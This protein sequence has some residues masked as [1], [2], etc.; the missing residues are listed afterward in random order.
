MP[1]KALTKQEFQ[2]II[3]EHH[4]GKSISTLSTELNRSSVTIIAILNAGTFEDYTRRN[5]RPTPTDTAVTTKKEDSA[6]KTLVKPVF[7]PGVETATITPEHLNS[8][9]KRIN[10]QHGVLLDEYR[11][12]HRTL[13]EMQLD[14]KSLTAAFERQERTAKALIDR[15]ESREK[16]AQIERTAKRNV[17]GWF[18][19]G[20]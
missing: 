14:F 16:V 11:L 2:K 5:R 20:K 6:T 17:L 15:I 7:G 19:R 8:T 1:R 3:N 10:K 13:R 18:R 9:F 12:I 4:K